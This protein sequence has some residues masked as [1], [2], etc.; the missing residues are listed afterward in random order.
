MVILNQILRYANISNFLDSFFFFQITNSGI[1]VE[2]E[3]GIKF[4]IIHEYVIIL[5]LMHPYVKVKTP[6]G[7]EWGMRSK[8]LWE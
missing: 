3:L 1:R 5:I 6:F 4:Y 8:Y 2:I 7:L